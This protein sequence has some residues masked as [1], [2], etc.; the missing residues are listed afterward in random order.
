MLC[1]VLELAEGVDLIS[2]LRA[3]K[4]LPEELVKLILLQV[5]ISLHNMKVKL[6]LWLS[7]QLEH[8]LQWPKSL[9][10]FHIY[11]L[12]SWIDWYR[13]LWVVIW[14]SFSSNDYRNTSKAAGTLHSM[15]PEM[16]NLYMKRM[17]ESEIDYKKDLVS[18]PSDYYTLGILAIEL[19]KGSPP[20]GYCNK[21]STMEK[22]K[23]YL[24]LKNQ[25][26]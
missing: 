8:P 19:L 7:A 2:L 23:E 14:V 3:Y 20:N 4:C 21:D 16:A 11:K 22:I 9:A 12:K 10:C 15:S 25:A 1:L 17:L 18:F 13:P 24:L 5:S 6:Y 26:V